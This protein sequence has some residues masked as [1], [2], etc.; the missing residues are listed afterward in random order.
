MMVY[1]YLLMNIERVA[2]CT[3][4]SLH[5]FTISSIDVS[6]DYK[7]LCLCFKSSGCLVQE[8]LGVVSGAMTRSLA[9]GRL[10]PVHGV[11]FWLAYLPACSFGWYE[12]L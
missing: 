4:F 7:S 10:A 6:E 1:K 5:A 11:L 3:T 2:T 9:G 8:T 12:L